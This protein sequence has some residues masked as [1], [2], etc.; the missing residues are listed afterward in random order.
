VRLIALLA[1]LSAM[2]AETE[3]RGQVRFGGAPVPGALVQAMRGETTVRAMTDAEGRYVFGSLA[4][5]E[6]TVR[7][8]MPGF[9]AI[10]RTV[11]VPQEGAPEQWELRMVRLDEIDGT[12]TSAF[13]PP[14]AV[15]ADDAA[16]GDREAATRLLINGSVVNG[17]ATNLGLQRAFGNVRIPRSPYRGTASIRGNSSFFD[18]RAYSLTGQDPRQPG[19]GR[20]QAS[21]ALSGP[22]LIPRLFRMGAFTATYSRTDNRDTSLETARVPTEAERR[23]EFSSF[24]IP[25]NDI[26]P[27]ARALVGLYPLPNVPGEA[28]NYQIPIVGATHG[29]SFQGNIT[30][31]RIGRRDQ[32]SGT[33]G[34]QTSRSDR[35]D[36]FGF[37]DSAKSS[38]TS[39]SVNWIHRFT[40]R[41]T[42]NIR[43]EFSR[44]TTHTIPHFANRQ[45]I[46]GEAGIT[47]NDRDPRNW[48]PPALSF[49]SG[50]ARLASG[51][52]ADD[53]IWSDAVSYSST[54]VVGRHALTYGADQRWQRFDLF[55]QRDAR[56]TFAFTGAATGNDFAD[57]LLGIPSASSL[58]FGNADKYFRQSFTSVFV[59]DDFRLTPSL[60]VNAGVRWEYE[61]PITE[62]DGRLVNLDVAPD[63]SSAV[64]LIASTSEN[65]LVRPDKSGI[66]PRIALAW[67]PWLASSV[68]I[69]GAY[70]VYR[71]TN[72]YR[73]IADQMSQQ[74]PLSKSLSV[75]NTL[76]NP[77]TLADG[78]RG[79]PT[80]TATT[81]AV[82]PDFRVGM[83]QHWQ[84]SIQRD[85]PWA[86]QATVSYLA[87]KGTHVPQRLLPNTFASGAV[88][89][90]PECPTGFVYLT[91]NGNSNR[92]SGTIEVRRRQRN[93]FEASAR[94]TLAKAI[95]DAGLGSSH[96]VQDWRKVAAERA[97][98]NFDRR[99]ELVVQAQYTSGMRAG[100]GS[101]WEGWGGR[102][103]N[104]W[105][106][107]TE[108]TAG[109]GLPLTPILLRPVGR[110]GVTGTLRPNV[111]GMPIDVD[112]DGRHVNPAAFVAPA[113]GEWGNAGRNSIRGPGQFQFN[114]SLARSFRFTQRVSMDLRID[115]TNLLNRV[116]FPDW[117]TVVGSSLFGLPTRANG[118]RTLTP[119]IRM[120]W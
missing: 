49:A 72:V 64:P 109:S 42:A 59:N 8:E 63:F 12:A 107:T 91:S 97:P 41:V 102:L 79:S 6:W 7:V 83:A 51:T 56:G 57:F 10:S 86:M 14:S 9:D 53:R 19:Y 27:Q 113:P 37:T 11:R 46:S 52:Y 68:L 20:M 66:Q 62:R 90:C 26:S 25:A 1:L 76:D 77:L 120:R 100:I 73:S 39:A 96:I 60:T 93:G 67:R 75:Q 30:N 13:P 104:S 116:T 114:A 115:A 17:A 54:W 31:I 40:P 3:H 29:D 15:A 5:G 34:F 35:P 38:S 98:S 48:G 94:Y 2:L 92:H 82:D 74:A 32:V 61:A 58:A 118:M 110:T 85:L 95:D 84:G 103:L 28:Y 45:D 101:F 69:R 87:I 24:S 70:G 36:L 18:A 108:L 99:H 111:T 112:V 22:L 117:N 44:T 105:T 78:F 50:V 89:P 119:S 23:G 47:G 16:T 88:T 81:F 21:I 43:Y 55:S 33:A 71:E 4:D 80:V 106:V 65:S